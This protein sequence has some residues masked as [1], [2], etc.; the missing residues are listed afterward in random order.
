MESLVSPESR[1]VTPPLVTD[2]TVPVNIFIEP[3]VRLE[4]TPTPV[5]V[6]EF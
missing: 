2:V 6:P 4:T 1:Y 3:F 5:V